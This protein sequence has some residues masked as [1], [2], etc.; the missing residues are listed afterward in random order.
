MSRSQSQNLHFSSQQQQ[1]HGTTSANQSRGHSRFALRNLPL[2]RLIPCLLTVPRSS[3][4]RPGQLRNKAKCQSSNVH[5]SPRQHMHFF[6]GERERRPP[7]PEIIRSS[8]PPWGNRK[9]QPDPSA[10]KGPH[11]ERTASLIT[12]PPASGKFFCILGGSM[13]KV[14]WPPSIRNNDGKRQKYSGE[15]PR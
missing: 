9:G 10:M 3:S 13:G 11:L 1:Q 15:W 6:G 7:L 8:Y 12:V 5:H 14:Q 4:S 2:V